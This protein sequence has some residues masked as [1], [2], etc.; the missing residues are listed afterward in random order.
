MDLACKTFIKCDMKVYDLI[1]EN[2]SLL[3]MLQH[4]EIDFRVDDLTVKQICSNKG[5][6]ENL[7]IAVAN[8]YNGFKPKAN[9]IRDIEDVMHIIKFLRNSHIYYREDKYPEISNY[10]HQLQEKHPGKE[11]VLLE[12]FFNV[13]FAEVIDH[14]AYE[15]N[16]AFPYFVKLINER[17]GNQHKVDSEYSAREYSE[18][19]TDIELKLKDLKS[20]L[21]K[22]IS[23][24]SDLTLKRKLL[25]SLFELEYDLYIHSLIEETILIPFGYNMETTV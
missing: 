15:D 9:P 24:R 3:L 4:F 22:H 11:L 10:I 18:H 14:L 13:Y 2:H 7:F 16:V 1:E 25:N 20:L 19:H 21:L 8:L 12:Q 23:I 5:I 17:Q 6:S